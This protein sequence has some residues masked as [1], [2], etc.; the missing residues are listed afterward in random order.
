M[1]TRLAPAVLGRT[2]GALLIVALLV[3]GSRVLRSPGHKMVVTAVFDRAGLNVRPGYEVRVRDYPVGTI[4]DIKVDRKNFDAVYTLKLDSGTA[5]ARDTHAVLV[6][7]TLFGDKYVQLDPAQPGQ[8]ELRNGDR[9]GLTQTQNPVEIQ[10]VFD[11]AAPLLQA[12][13]PPRFG[14]A[15]ASMSQGLA[16]EGDDLRRLTD[17]WTNVMQEFASHGTD[18]QTLLTKVPGVA[19]TFAERSQ[20]LTT[21]AD[22]LG[23]VAAVLAKNE[24]TLGPLLT[25]NAALADKAADL[26]SNQPAR[27]G[28]IIP[29]MVDVVALTDSMPGRIAKFAKS[30]KYNLR[31]TANI[32][33]SGWIQTRVTN[34]FILNW[35]TIYDAPGQYGDYNGG[36]GV[37]PDIDVTGVPNKNVPVNLSPSQKA[38][39]ATGLNTLLAP[40]TGGGQ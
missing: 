22:D 20:D 29:D 16:G 33:S 32:M 23:Q 27:L 30:V 26:L 40:L 1:G 5:V 12:L 6:P 24:P 34:T 11:E 15:L 28:Q 10:Q 14:A 8:P 31:G 36:T 21:A 19:G 9:I 13:D 25:Q 18:L 38:A 7:K 35:G 17:G 2:I 39:S 4:S 37:T 3:V